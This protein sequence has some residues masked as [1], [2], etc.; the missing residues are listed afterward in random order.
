MIQTFRVQL[1]DDPGSEK[2]I[3]A[4]NER[5]AARLFIDIF[6]TRGVE[7]HEEA[8]VDVTRNEGGDRSITTRWIVRGWLQRVYDATREGDRPLWSI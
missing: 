3:R 7:F 1:V 5:D 2:D 6:D 4:T 8:R